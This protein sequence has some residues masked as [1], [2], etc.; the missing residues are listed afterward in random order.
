MGR[1]VKK[2]IQHGH[3]HGHGHEKRYV[4]GSYLTK[5]YGLHNQTLVKW[6]TTGKL[7]AIRTPGGKRMYSISSFLTLIKH[8]PE[9]TEGKTRKEEEECPGG[10]KGTAK[11]KEEESES[12]SGDS[13]QEYNICY[14]RVSSPHQK[15]DL[16]RQ[17]QY[18]QQQYPNH[19]LISDIGSGLNFHRKGFLSLLERVQQGNVKEVVVL[20]PDRLCRFGMELVQWI[21]KK[22]GTKLVVH[23]SLSHSNSNSNSQTEPDSESSHNQ[24]QHQQQQHRQELADDILSVVNFFVAQNN[25]RRAQENRRARERQTSLQTQQDKE[26]T[27]HGES[28]QTQQDGG[29][30]LATGETHPTTSTTEQGSE[31]NRSNRKTEEKGRRRV[32]TG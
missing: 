2:H 4:P 24:Q 19:F 20:Y 31:E 16:Q 26:K 22:A 32:R 5:T 13:Q 9:S 28:H 17:V 3:G 25:G 10:R 15:E 6:H 12:E 21:F 23:S 8:R 27:Q 30:H 18:L 11:E 7:E 14:A 1:E 29:G